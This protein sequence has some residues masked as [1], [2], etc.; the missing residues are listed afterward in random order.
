MDADVIVIGAGVALVLGAVG[1]YGVIAYIVSQKTREIG[2]RMALGARKLDIALWVLREGLGLSLLGI[3]IGWRLS[4]SGDPALRLG[5][6]QALVDGGLGVD[7]LYLTLVAAPVLALAR[8]VA[9]VD[10]RVV[11]APVRAVARQAVR[12]SD[13]VGD[14]HPTRPLSAVSMVGAGLVVLLAVA[15]TV[16][17]LGGSA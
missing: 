8:G 15:V 6:R 5:R 7:R 14:R 4:R 10:R 2:V 1:I 17:L 13:T 11:D 3:G 16:A 9:T 12:W